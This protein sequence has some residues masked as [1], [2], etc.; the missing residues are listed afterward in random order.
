MKLGSFVALQCTWSSST[1]FDSQSIIQCQ[2][3]SKPQ[4]KIQPKPWINGFYPSLGLGCYFPT[5]LYPN[6][7]ES[8]W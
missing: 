3:N 8:Q 4:N 2:Q 6:V 7:P 5:K 1:P